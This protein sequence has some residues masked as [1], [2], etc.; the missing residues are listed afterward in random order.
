MQSRAARETLRRHRIDF[1]CQG[2]RLFSEICSEFGLDPQAILAEIA[3]AA[4]NEDSPEAWAERT[5][6]ELIEHIMKRYHEPL[7]EELPQLIELAAATETGNTA[8]PL[9]PAGLTDHLRLSLE[10]VEE[11][12]D[13]EEELFFPL[14]MR[15][16]PAEYPTAKLRDQHEAHDDGLRKLREITHD[17]ELPSGADAKWI[18]LYQRLDLFEAELMEHMHL[19]NNILF[20]WFPSA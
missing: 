10:A 2:K 17:L 19:E 1:C 8:H 20:E 4:E 7:R 16:E 15:E 3:I 11:H 5:M 13:L 6:V 14:I 9:C 18:D 12:L